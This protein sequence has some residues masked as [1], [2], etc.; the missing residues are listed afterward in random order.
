MCGGARAAWTR[1]TEMKPSLS[2]FERSDA[3]LG[4]SAR[5][6]PPDYARDP[7]STT[8]VDDLILLGCLGGS[9]HP[10]KY[11]TG[12]DRD[13]GTDSA[14]AAGALP[15]DGVEER[16]IGPIVEGQ[17]S[18]ATAARQTALQGVPIDLRLHRWTQPGIAP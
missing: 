5:E 8:A 1:D 17:D 7:R 14:R 10:Q 13:Y 9:A 4:T 11:L 16:R 3:I 18:A 2:D 6:N 15:I 12:E